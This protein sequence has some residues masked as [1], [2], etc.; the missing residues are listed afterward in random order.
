MV[1]DLNNEYNVLQFDQL[2]NLFSATKK[3]MLKLELNLKKIKIIL[4]YLFYGFD[5][6]FALDHI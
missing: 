3:F 1:L 6:G 4:L 2:F 5:C